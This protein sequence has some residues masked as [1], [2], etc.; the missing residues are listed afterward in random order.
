MKITFD[1]GAFNVDGEQLMAY[2]CAYRNAAR[3]GVVNFT[4][5]GESTSGVET[6]RFVDELVALAVQYPKGTGVQR[7]A[8]RLLE[9]LARAGLD[10]MVLQACE[11]T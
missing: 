11:S 1:V 2:D 9:S 10:A 3:T 6:S 5:G 8:R 7:G 4:V